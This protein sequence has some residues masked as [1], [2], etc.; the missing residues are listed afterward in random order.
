MSA[1]FFGS[2]PGAGGPVARWTTMHHRPHHNLFGQLGNTGSWPFML[3][4]FGRQLRDAPSDRRRSS[5]AFPGLRRFHILSCLNSLLPQFK[6][7]W[8]GTL[9]RKGSIVAAGS[10]NIYS[11]TGIATVCVQR[12]RLL[13]KKPPPPSNSTT[14]TMICKV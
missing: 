11:L 12:P 2:T 9:N 5:F 3:R 1:E 7:V 4:S 10:A 13:K 8:A 14:T 6:L